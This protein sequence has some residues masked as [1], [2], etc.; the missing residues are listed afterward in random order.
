MAVVGGQERRADAPGHVDQLRVGLPLLVEAVVLQ[1]DEQV[2][3]PEDV[4]QPGGQGGGLLDVAP[5]QGLA[6]PPRRGTRW[7][8]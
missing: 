4:L 6:A 2:V 3:P 7:W 1:L 5:Q 8:R